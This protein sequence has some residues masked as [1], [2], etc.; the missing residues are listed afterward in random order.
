MLYCQS[1]WHRYQKCLTTGQIGYYFQ[2][3]DNILLRERLGTW[4]RNTVAGAAAALTR[5]EFTL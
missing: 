2:V 5:N 3:F 4:R 1:P